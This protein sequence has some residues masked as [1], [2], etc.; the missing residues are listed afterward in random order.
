MRVS[1]LFVC[2][3]LT[4]CAEIIRLAEPGRIRAGRSYSFEIDRDWVRIPARLDET[5]LIDSLTID[6]PLL[7]RVYFT[8]GLKSGRAFV[9]A[10]SA[11][12]PA[13]VFQSAMSEAELAEFVADSL[14]ALGVRDVRL[15]AAGPARLAGAPGMRA[16]YTGARESG[17]RVRAMALGAIYED[18]LD[19]IV[20]IAPQEHYFEA[21][22]GHVEHM[23]ATTRRETR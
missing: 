1:V 11:A 14:F 16:M 3:I 17:L 8:G 4:G 19:L 13:P 10:Q 6:G 7:N 23:F 18:R 21:Y 9:S 2:L 22:S 15:E 20:F 5:V 12:R